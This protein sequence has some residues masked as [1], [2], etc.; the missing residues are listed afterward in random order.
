M[1]FDTDYCIWTRAVLDS[2]GNCTRFNCCTAREATYSYEPIDAYTA[3]ST[4]TPTNARTQPHTH[5]HTHTHKHVHT[6]ARASYIFSFGR[7]FEC[8]FGLHLVPHPS[9]SHAHSLTHSLT[10]MSVQPPCIQN[11][12]TLLHEACD[13]GQVHC[14]KLLIGLNADPNLPNKVTRG[15]GWEVTPIVVGDDACII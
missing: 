1:V 9:P 8:V 12:N 2:S 10:H 14:A 6:H 5:T 13:G 15:E 3:T 11:G 4:A 7:W